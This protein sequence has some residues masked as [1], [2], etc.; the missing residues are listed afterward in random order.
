MRTA[1]LR[2]LLLSAVALAACALVYG[3]CGYD[4]LKPAVTVLVHNIPANADHLEV[5]LNDSASNS[6]ARKPAL[7]TG[8]VTDL[9]VDFPAP[10]TGVVTVQ[11]NALDHNNTPLGTATVSGNYQS[12]VLVLE[13]TLSISAGQPGGYGGPCQSGV[14]GPSLVCKKY[15]GTEAGV[16]THACGTGGSAC[17]T[18]PAGASCQPFNSSAGQTYCQWECG[19]ADAGTSCPAN[20]TCGSQLSTGKKFCQGSVP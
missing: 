7:G 3:A 10:A 2:T 18:S 6:L 1:P 16:C 4:E 9:E 8:S 20:L 11:V 12:P 15:T 13:T 17:E 5:D 14:C 19:L